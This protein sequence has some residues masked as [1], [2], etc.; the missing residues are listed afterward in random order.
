MKNRLNSA[1]RRLWRDRDGAVL[2]IIAVS[3]PVIL[4]MTALSIDYGYV[5]NVKT[6]LQS[7]TEA[8]ALAG[9]QGLYDDTYTAKANLYSSSAAVGGLNIINDVTV[10]AP[11]IATHC[12]TTMQSVVP[13]VTGK[14]VNVIQVTQTAQA[15]LFFG[16]AIGLK[17]MTVSATAYAAAAGSSLPA[18]NVMIVLDTTG[19]MSSSDPKCV[20]NKTTETKLDC[21]EIG[22]QEMLGALYPTI[23]YV[24]L[25][26]FPGLTSASA[27]GDTSCSGRNPTKPQPVEYGS[28]GFSAS[29]ATDTYTIVGLSKCTTGASGTCYRSSNTASSLNTSSPMVEAVGSSSSSMGCLKNPAGEGTYFAD[30][31][32][33]AQAALEAFK[34]SLGSAG[35]N[36]QNVIVILSDGDANAQSGSQ[37]VASE[38]SNQC[39]EAVTASDNAKAAGTWVY[40]IGYDPIET[41]TDTT[42]GSGKNKKTTP[43]TGCITDSGPAATRITPYC[44]LLEMASTPTSKYF[45]SDEAPPS[46]SCNGVS[47]PPASGNVADLFQEVGLTLSQ[48]RLIPQS[49]YN[50]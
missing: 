18:L 6:R 37:I 49:A 45:F 10:A 28:P 46:A 3:L 38:A 31:I 36:T 19:S 23:D 35:A 33:A 7:T 44:T 22:V 11:S 24:G 27:S 41:D 15:P 39:K 20:I 14:T 26:V 13:C 8:A 47:G 34:S 17:P 32:T 21:A 25:E 40:A 50:N 30:A 5:L 16:S 1:I 48:P 9:A 12:S 2:P 4:G 43:S 42:T 29:P